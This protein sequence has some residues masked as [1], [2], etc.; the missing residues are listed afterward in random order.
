[1]K[2]NFGNDDETRLRWMRELHRWTYIIDTKCRFSWRAC[3]P[4]LLTLIGLQFGTLVPLIIFFVLGLT[5]AHLSIAIR[6]SFEA[7]P[8]DF[9]QAHGKIGG[10]V[11]LV[12]FDCL[13][14]AAIVWIAFF[15]N[16]AIVD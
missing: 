5:S 12:I 13:I 7:P 14:L 15:S 3:L 16:L 9:L 1:M 10:L 6:W 2:L 4:L 11:F 8:K